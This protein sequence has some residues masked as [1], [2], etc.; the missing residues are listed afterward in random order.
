MFHG[1]LSYDGGSKATSLFLKTV[2]QTHACFPI[3]FLKV[4]MGIRYFLLSLSISKT[5]APQQKQSP[6]GVTP[7]VAEEQV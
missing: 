4:L 7:P 1:K 5:L 3:L 2:P 6:K